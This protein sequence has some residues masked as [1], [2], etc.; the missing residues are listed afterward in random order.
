M[1]KQIKSYQNGLLFA[2]FL[3]LNPLFRVFEFK[4]HGLYHAWVNPY[5]VP[6]LAGLFMLLACGVEKISEHFA[7]GM[8]GIR[9]PVWVLYIGSIAMY[10]WISERMGG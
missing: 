1:E 3:L 7:K 9:I 8:K 10:L 2:F 6:I 5:T 4:L